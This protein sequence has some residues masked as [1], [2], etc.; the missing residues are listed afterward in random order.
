MDVYK[1]PSHWDL[2]MR[3]LGLGM[4]GLV[5]AL[6]LLIAYFAGLWL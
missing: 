6:V 2:L 5:L 3:V 1:K 4:D